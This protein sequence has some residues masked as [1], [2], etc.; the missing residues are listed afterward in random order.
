MYPL[1]LVHEACG[2]SNE[3]DMQLFFT[4]LELTYLFDSTQ[5]LIMQGRTAD[6][7][8]LWQTASEETKSQFCDLQTEYDP[9][10]DNRRYSEVI[11][12]VWETISTQLY[13][14]AQRTEAETSEGR[15]SWWGVHEEFE[16]GGSPIK[17]QRSIHQPPDGTSGRRRQDR[18]PD[19]RH[20]GH[21]YGPSPNDRRSH[22]N[23]ADLQ[24]SQRSR[25]HPHPT[26]HR[27]AHAGGRDVYRV[28]GIS[29]DRRNVRHV[30]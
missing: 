6:I 7:L 10:Q 28:R 17:N 18:R 21:P 3:Y 30:W 8:P 26:E 1:S 22:T 16:Q 14:T 27:A 2:T 15:E 25:V 13:K 12:E 4:K 19:V 24:T 20:V 23:N 5:D 29:Y 9:H 11:N